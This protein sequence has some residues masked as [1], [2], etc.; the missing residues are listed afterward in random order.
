MAVNDLGAALSA[1]RDAVIECSKNGGTVR[2]TSH[3]DCDGIVSGSIM[4]RT[5]DMAGIDHTVHNTKGMDSDEIIRMKDSGAGLH[6]V[7][8]LGSGFSK[9]F[10][11]ALGDRWYVLDHH[12]MHGDDEV[13]P[14]VVNAW[15]YGMDGSIDICAGGMAYLAAVHFNPANADLS[16]IAVVSA[17]GDRQDKGERRSLVGI[18]AEIASTAA[19]LGLVKRELDLMLAGRGTKPI[20]DAIAFT[21]NPNIPGVTDERDM[22][23]KILISAGIKL[24]DGKRLRFPADLTR[25]EKSKILEIL[26]GRA[27][28]SG[29]GDVVDDLVGYAYTMPNENQ[30]SYIGDCR[31]FAT[32]LNSCGRMGRYD[33]GTAI[34]IGDREQGLAD[35]MNIM[36]DYK[37]TLATFMRKVNAEPGMVEMH[38]G[39]AL[40][41]AMNSIPETMT[42]T[43]CSMLASVKR[44]AGKVVI[45]WTDGENDTVK[46]SSRKSPDCTL[47]VNLND[48]MGSVAS[49]F[50]GMG[51]GHDAAAGATIQIGSLGGF[52]DGVKAMLDGA[53]HAEA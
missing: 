43:V 33:I 24:T 20:Q 50:S 48:I 35:L 10:D 28:M 6:I 7:T 16:A 39:Y 22:C 44:Y 37:S 14:R 15:K 31:E 3:I 5:L 41:N 21:S 13:H 18:N 23:I 2:V 25:D 42:G 19:D 49:T 1:I 52:L 45:L 8:D 12:T 29:V 47:Q 17:I 30:R 46:F 40:V 36:G 32:A 34:C 27:V 53:K 51:G 38:D 9:E 11:E 4:S 26:A